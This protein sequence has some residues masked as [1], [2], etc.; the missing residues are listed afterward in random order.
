MSKG[1]RE[2]KVASV[3]FMQV[4]DYS[5]Q[6]LG[7][8]R[9]YRRCTVC[10]REDRQCLQRRAV[11]GS[12]DRHTEGPYGKRGTLGMIAS[13]SRS[14]MARSSSSAALTIIGL[15]LQLAMCPTSWTVKWQS[16]VRE[17]DDERWHC[18]DNDRGRT[19]HTCDSSSAV[20]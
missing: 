1:S 8:P 12:S 19:M 5:H 3:F 14:Q 11:R 17:L 4:F 10:A 7:A 18:D 6:Y 15:A 9:D 16:V 13:L 20:G 2:N